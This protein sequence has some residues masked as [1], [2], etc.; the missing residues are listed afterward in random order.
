MT[1]NHNALAA[2]EQVEVVQY[3]IS[4]RSIGLV[5]TLMGFAN[6]FG[7]GHLVGICVSQCVG[8]T[9][10]TSYGDQDHVTVMTDKRLSIRAVC[11]IIKKCT[12][13]GCSCASPS[14]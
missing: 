11:F 12:R 1:A 2:V 9:G 13:A 4:H 10:G 6:T 5:K 8:T 14:S 3:E 7:K